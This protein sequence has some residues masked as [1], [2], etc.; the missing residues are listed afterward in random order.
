MNTGLTL[1]ALAARITS[2]RALLRDYVGNT[3]LMTMQPTG[4]ITLQ[5]GKLLDLGVRRIAHEQIAEKVGIPFKYYDRMLSEQPELLAT[6]VNTWFTKEPAPRL[7][8]VIGDEARAFLS[9]S[10]RPLDNYDVAEHLLPKL[11]DSGLEVVSSQITESRLYI[12]ARSTRIQGEVKVGDVVQSGVVISNSEVGRGSLSI[13]ELDYR[14]RC[15][16]GMVGEDVVRKT[17]TGAARR[18]D[19]SFA[20]EAFTPATRQLTDRA[21]WAQARDAVDT[22]L[23][24][25]R[26]AKRL[27]RMR[28]AA[29][30]ELKNPAKAIDTIVERFELT[31][32]EGSGI[33][34]H[35]AKGGDVTQWGLANAVTA[36]AHDEADYDRGFDFEKLGTRILELPR[37]TFE[38]N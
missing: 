8:R 3:R 25:D 6:N 13:A 19:V 1:N 7:V 27:D 5:N 36:M 32:T 24:P 14:L 22:L 20:E 21:F 16:N 4:R 33:L 29:G 23:S 9:D 28:A 11:I 15:L 30:V 2:D 35:F 26:F 12:Q 34:A 31:K 38:N 37:A 17:H 18:G 10:Y